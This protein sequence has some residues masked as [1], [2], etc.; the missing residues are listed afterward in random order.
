VS[1]FLFDFFGF[2]AKDL[3]LK[4]KVCI[5][6]LKVSLSLISNGCLRVGR[7]FSGED[8]MESNAE[9]ARLEQF[10]D[11]LLTK[12]HELKS[13]HHAVEATLKEREEE[14]LE[15]KEK[16]AG[17]SNEKTVVSERVSGLI[18]RI[19]QWESEQLESAEEEQGQETHE[20]QGA[21]TSFEEQEQGG[22]QASLFAPEAETH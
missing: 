12:Y 5:I 1:S 13:E 15:L 21:Q 7:L 10:V 17:L 22:E 9:L 2:Q 20:F 3:R 14:C 19:E 18:G 11:K 4:S 6:S 16:I 8:V